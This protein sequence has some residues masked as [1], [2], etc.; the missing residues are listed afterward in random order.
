MFAKIRNLDDFPRDKTLYVTSLISLIFTVIIFVLMRPVEAELKSLTPYGVMELE[1]AWTVAQIDD[2]FTA[3][4]NSLIMKELG[5]TL[6]D[7]GFLVFYSTLMAGITLILTRRV[8]KGIM[9][10]WGFK[11]AL[12]PFLAASF[13][14]IENINL[15]IMLTSPSSYPTF[16]P[17]VASVCATIKFSLLGG[18][19][20]YWLIGSFFSFA[21]K[22]KTENLTGQ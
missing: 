19:V 2:I 13:D 15:I 22:G 14:I 8:F 17:F 5:V 16:A 21:Q 10:D 9:K 18:T 12:V 11:F 20:V 4:G 7:F 6:L 3:W 1:F